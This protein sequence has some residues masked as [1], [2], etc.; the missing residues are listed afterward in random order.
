M[1]LTP[2][3]MKHLEGFRWLVHP[4]LRAQGRT[5]LLAYA[6]ISTAIELQPIPVSIIGHVNGHRAAVETFR[7]I[8]NL[9]EHDI[10]FRNIQWKLD[11]AMMQLSVG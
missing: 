8:A 7:M 10:E 6:I 1:K 11:S 5:T 3:Q 2:E 4:T 9:L